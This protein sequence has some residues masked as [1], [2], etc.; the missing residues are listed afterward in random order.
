MTAL[1]ET[2]PSP[3]AYVTVQLP[4]VADLQFSICPGHTPVPSISCV[5][6]LKMTHIDNSLNKVFFVANA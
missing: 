2:L 3:E 4:A 1:Q 6:Y 5:V